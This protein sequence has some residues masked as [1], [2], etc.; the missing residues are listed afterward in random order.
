MLLHV[1]V[2]AGF[3]EWGI[4]ELDIEDEFVYA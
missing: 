4:L 3:L 2:F 1:K